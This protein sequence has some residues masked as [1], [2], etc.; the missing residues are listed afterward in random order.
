MRADA[1]LYGSG[2]AE[3]RSKAQQMIREGCVYAGGK[4]VKKPS[5]DLPEDTVFSIVRLTESFVGRGGVKLLAALSDF[6]IDPAGMHCLD[7]GASTGGFTDCLLKKGA[8]SVTAVDCGRDQLAPSL[9]ADPRVRSVEGLNARYMTREDVGDGYDLAVM[10]LSFISLTY[11]LPAIPPL[12]GE[13][14]RIVALIKP[15]FELDAKSV[16]KG[17]VRGAEKRLKALERVYDF[18][19]GVGLTPRAFSV[20]PIK[21]GDGNTEYL[22]FL[23]KTREGGKPAFRRDGLKELARDR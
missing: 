10:D 18:L 6:G 2:L 16:S 11:V 8:A 13:S 12:L 19:P 23:E 3:S 20:S 22:C 4:P 21:G 7:V 1:L 15:Q 5:A 14:G 9:R 17:V